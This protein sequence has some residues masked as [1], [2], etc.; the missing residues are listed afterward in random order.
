MNIFKALDINCQI[1]SQMSC[2]NFAP[3]NVDLDLPIT[4]NL[5][6]SFNYIHPTTMF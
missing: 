6:I 1:T 5:L 4:L 3:G 2:A